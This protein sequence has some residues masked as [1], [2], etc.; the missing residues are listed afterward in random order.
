MLL[1]SLDNYFL[2]SIE[3]FILFIFFTSLI[4]NSDKFSRI[5]FKNINT[6]N[7]KTFYFIY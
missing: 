2:F 1:K 3:A 7:F 6:I 4:K 5:N